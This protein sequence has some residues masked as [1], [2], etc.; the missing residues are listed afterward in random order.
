MAKKTAAPKTL[1]KG[2]TTASELATVGVVGAGISSLLAERMARDV[3]KGVSKDQSD[4]MVPLIYILQAQSPQVMKR[5][6]QHIEGAE[7]GSIWLR[8]VADP[9][10]DGEEGILFQPCYF[11]KDWVEWIPRDAGGGFVGR[12][13][14]LP[15]D[16]KN[17]ADPRNPNRMN[18]MRPNGNQLRETRYHA[19][20]VHGRGA[21]MPFVIPMSSSGHTTSRAWMFLMNSKHLAGGGTA[22]SFSQLYRLRTKLR[23]NAQGEWYAWDVSEEGWVNSVKDYELGKALYD[24]FDSGTKAAEAPMH[25]EEGITDEI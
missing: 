15:S 13:A 1:S 23:T 25:E 17:I 4:N 2:K 6:A 18:Y 22:P 21:P 8:G 3:G 12:H 11:S 19:G 9:V 24:A 10:I 5:N 16:A 14:S 7:A 20:I